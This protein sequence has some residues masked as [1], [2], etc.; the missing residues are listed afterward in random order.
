M[1]Q[2]LF[3]NVNVLDCTDGELFAGEVRVR[4][5]RSPPRAMVNRSTAT[6]GGHDGEGRMTLMPAD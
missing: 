5:T 4:A 1:S 3:T 6:V 2:H